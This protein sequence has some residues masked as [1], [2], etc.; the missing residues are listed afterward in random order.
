MTAKVPQSGKADEPKSKNGA[1][2]GFEQKLWQ[3]AKLE[4]QFTESEKLEA[5]IR[6]NLAGLGYAMPKGKTS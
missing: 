2:L 5:M 6:K 4:E 3:A 1:N